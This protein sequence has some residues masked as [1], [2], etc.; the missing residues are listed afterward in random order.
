[1]VKCPPW[2]NVTEVTHL[3]QAV[4]QIMVAIAKRIPEQPT[5]DQIV[6]LSPFMP[7]LEEAATQ[8]TAAIPDEDLVRPFIG[9]GRFYEGKG[10]YQQAE[11]WLQQC[12]EI[13]ETRLGTDHPHFA[14]SL[15]NLALLYEVQG[16]YSESEPLL[17]RSLAIREQQLGVNHSDVATSLNN[18]ARLYES[19]GRYSEAEPLLVRSWIILYF[20]FGKDHPNTQKVMS[21]LCDFLQKMMSENR[22]AELSNHLLTQNLLAYLR[23]QAE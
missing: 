16:R 20:V 1:M 6:P 14:A 3:K 9:L 5:Q 12:C 4:A 10:F 7:H 17:V 2:L 8:L 15:N 21:N 19:Q 11:P 18:L 13:V 23:Q 22:T